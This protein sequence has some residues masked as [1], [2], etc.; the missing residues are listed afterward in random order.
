MNHKIVEKEAFQIVGKGI[1]VSTVNGENQRVIPAFWDESNG[2]GFTLELEKNSGPMGLLGACMQF[3]RLNEEFVYFIG[4]EKNIVDLPVEWEEKTIPA[5]TW[6]VFE[7]VGPMPESIQ[8]VWGQIYSEW[9][10]S[11]GYEHG[12]APELEVY[13]LED[14]NDENYRCEV[15]IPVV[16]K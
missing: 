4:A 10:P 8:K 13:P 2:N 3:D 7:S 12:D 5:S 1:K 9:F 15:W 14:P 6:A 11:S 16:K